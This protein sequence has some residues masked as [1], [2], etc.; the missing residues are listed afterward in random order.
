VDLVRHNGQVTAHLVPTHT[1]SRHA[2]RASQTDIER[3]DYLNT[4]VA[5]TCASHDR[6]VAG[7]FSR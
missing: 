2:Q 1:T 4:H 3:D 5:A 7:R 6:S